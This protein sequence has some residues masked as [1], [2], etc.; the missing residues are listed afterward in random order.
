MKKINPKL[1]A[2][3]IFA[4]S[5]LV[6]GG[7]WSTL[8]QADQYDDQIR[9]LQQENNEKQQI[10]NQLAAQANS[11]EDAVNKL[12]TQINSLQ[13]AIIANQQ[14][15][16]DLQ[17]QIEEGERELAHQKQV[18]G[19]NIKTMYLEG[20][21][22]TLLI[23]ASSK[24]ISEYVTKEQYRAAVQNQIKATVDKITELKQKLQAQK[25]QIEDLIK[26]QEVQRSQVA[27]NRAE[28]AS[29]LAYTEAQKAGYDQQ[30]KGNKSKISE[31]RRQQ[32]IANA[33]YN[34]G[35]FRGDPSN[36]GY[37]NVWA[38]APQDSIVDTWGMYNRECVSYTAFM[39][40]QDF[41]A[42]RNNR[43][44]PY[45]GGRGDAKNWDDNARA[46]GIPVDSNPTPGSIGISNEGTWGHSVYVEAVNG[47]QIYIKQYN[48]GFSGQYSEGW[49]YA[50]GLV[51]LHF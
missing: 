3:V 10:A 4:S 35:N 33:R 5:L 25:Q 12:Q 44:M 28:Q 16:S 6:G 45:W 11:Y 14:Q 26:A 1:L 8:V 22:S 2:I 47:N 49:R 7:L 36:G 42:D 38:Y 31:L 41:L 51:F 23:L 24:D 19:N 17:Q 20:Q 46:A 32:A 13:Q 21:I 43:D 48:A 9:S 50:T 29:L 39:V 15:S 37:P 27:A 40:H 18:L 30:I 34:I